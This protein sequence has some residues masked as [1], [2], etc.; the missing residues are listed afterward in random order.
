MK[1]VGDTLKAAR[2]EKDISIESAAA[3]T[4]ISVR[5]LAAL[6]ANDFSSFP[7][8]TYLNG[9]LKSYAE[10]LGLDAERMLTLYRNYKIG[11]EPTPMAALMEK[12]KSKMLPVLL[13]GIAAA[14]IM[15]V[16]MLFIVPKIMLAREQK[17]L[18]E[19]AQLQAAAENANKLYSME[20]LVLDQTLNVG[21][22]LEVRFTDSL[23]YRFVFTDF[24]GSVATVERYLNSEAAPAE[25]FTLMLGDEKFFLLNNYEK[26]DFLIQVIDIG[27]RDGKAVRFRF[28][29][30]DEENFDSAQ[31]VSAAAEESDL[32]VAEQ[33]QTA[34]L[35]R[36]SLG[37]QVVLSIPSP[38]Q[39]DVILSFKGYCYFRYRLDNREQDERYYQE[40][41]R[42][43]RNM[44]SNMR[45]WAS[46][47]DKAQLNIGLNKV[48]LGKDGEV[49]VKDL[50]WIYN[51]ENGMWDLVLDNVT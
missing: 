47:A 51:R 26:A 43:Q 9:F 33:Q 7:S 36:P 23:S 25:I 3:E 6:E 14:G 27:L 50:R 10:F 39:M 32:Q 11:E 24:D 18:L 16:I 30:L 20:G 13:G 38:M 45:I 1:K 42:F 46:N 21:D 12:P 28:Q 5:Y 41:D 44:R 34:A 8:E 2:E 19:E 29:R 31:L 37:R 22:R 15:A 48:A 49:I 17:R 40:G 4:N 35:V